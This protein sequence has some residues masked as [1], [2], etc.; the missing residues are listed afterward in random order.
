M[1]KV[2]HATSDQRKKLFEARVCSGNQVLFCLLERSGD[3][4]GHGKEQVSCLEEIVL[5]RFPIRAQFESS[6]VASS[7]QGGTHAAH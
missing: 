4:E 5:R 6:R 1:S 7:G 3:E 2:E